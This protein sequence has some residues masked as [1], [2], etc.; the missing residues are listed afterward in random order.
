MLSPVR[1]GLAHQ[2]L[3]L[4]TV[5]QDPKSPPAELRVGQQQPGHFPTRTGRAAPWGAIQN[6]TIQS[7]FHVI[8]GSLRW[9]NLP[10]ASEPR[11]PPRGCRGTPQSGRGSATPPQQFSGRTRIGDSA[12]ACTQ[13]DVAASACT[14]TGT[15]WTCRSGAGRT[16]S[17]PL[18]ATGHG[19]RPCRCARQSLV[20]ARPPWTEGAHSPRVSGWGSRA[21]LRA[22][23][24]DARSCTT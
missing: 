19:R 18:A 16:P 13:A 10:V 14:A 22:A 23:T 6:R 9:R 15:H 24:R 20:P 5:T 3:Q 2:S 1:A 7:R 8:D 11:G 4:V 21:E 12:A 17:I